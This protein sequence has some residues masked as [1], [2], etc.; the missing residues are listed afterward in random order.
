MYPIISHI[1]VPNKHAWFI[2]AV[3]AVVVRARENPG[4][5]SA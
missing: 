4:T 5:Q 3:V 1:I 2:V